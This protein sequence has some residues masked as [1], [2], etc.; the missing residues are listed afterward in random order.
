MRFILILF[1]LF[2]N[3]IFA[4]F[5]QGP[6]PSNGYREAGNPYYWK[7]RKPHEAYWQQDVHYRMRANISD[8]TDIIDAGSELTYW[9]NSPDT[10][11]IVYFHLYQNAFQP[12]SY[13][14]DLNKN[15][16]V[17]PKYGQYEQQGLGTQIESL[18]INGSAPR[19]E[20]DN[21]IMRVILPSPLYPGQS[22]DFKIKFK[23]YFDSGSL[24]RRMK[25]FDASG[26]KHF[27]GVHWYPRI[28][29]YDA[30][31]GWNTDQ[32]LGKEFYGDYG[33]YDVELTF[34]NHYVMDATGVLLNPEEVYP[35]DLRQKLD[36]SNFKNKPYNSPAS[37]I[38]KADGTTKTWKFHAENVHDFAWTADPTYRIGELS[39]NGVKCIA[40]AQ[41][42][43]ASGWQEAPSFIAKV[44]EVYSK[45]FGMY[46]YPKMIA[47]DAQ[48][49]MEYPMLTLDGGSYPGYHNVIAHEIGHNWFFG[50]VGNNETYRA[51]LDEG[52]T[53]FLTSWSLM[54]ID[55]KYPLRGQ[56]KSKYLERFYKP[57]PTLESSVYMG[58]MTDAINHNDEQLNTHSDQFNA[59]LGHGGGYRHVYYKTAVMLYNLE[60]VLG[61]ELFLK[62]MQ[63]YFHQWKMCHPYFEDF[64]ASI[65]RYTKVDLNWFFDQ[66]LETT[67]R[68]D[69]G[70]SGVKRVE[71]NDQFNKYKISFVRRDRMQMPV[72]FTVIGKSGK[73]YDFH[74]PNTYFVKAT[75]A[76]I[77]PMW[78]GWDK[79][80][81]T[82]SAIVT[83][84]EEIADV[85]ID[86]TNRLA[87]VN[88]LDNSFHMPVDFGFDAQIN[89]PA[90]RHNYIF[91][92]RPDVWYN[93]IDGIKAGLHFNGNYMQSKHNFR[94]SM[95]YNTG[96]LSGNDSLESSTKRD[97]FSYVFAYNTA[98]GRNFHS[99]IERRFL[100]GLTATRL[101]L[102]KVQGAN[103][104][105]LSFKSMYRGD[106]N[107]LNYLLYPDYWR[108]NAWNNTINIDFSRNYDYSFGNGNI[109]LGGRSSALTEDYDYTALNMNVINENRFG[110][111]DIRTRTFIQY[112]RGNS[113]APESKL[114][115]AGANPEGLMESKYTRSR[116][117]VPTDWV[118]YGVDY[119]HFHAGGGLNLRGYSNYVV[120]V[121][122]GAGLDSLN[123]GY[124]GAAVNAE[125]DFD[126]LVNFRPRFTRN[127]LKLDAYLFGDIGIL[128]NRYAKG[129]FNNSGFRSD[130]GVGTAWT[131]KR[132][133]VLNQINPLTI[134]F[135][136][137]VVVSHA[138]FV[139]NEHVRF[140]WV[141]GISRAF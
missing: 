126:R 36:L 5:Y 108:E 9:N 48:D 33:T 40:L 66:W 120:P 130:A 11:R 76:T 52:F 87:D 93:S 58:Y 65:I 62:A 119:N 49:G 19:I 56:Y 102:E 54:R 95:W 30:K 139:N 51:A 100:D 7:N 73:E 34:P 27:D 115:L 24:R 3:S 44:V 22:I 61:E 133:G 86:I 74:I 140:R 17:K 21:T 141:V 138:P 23:T 70:I 109:K 50:M 55:G 94:F 96:V 77:L 98:L 71:K 104:Y 124:S 1:V 37:E 32:H 12:G 83:I 89:N 114:Y 84:P 128:Y 28:C 68:I 80:N 15:N 18:T 110:K 106:R 132:F 16:D 45:D 136:V 131:I 91:R 116:G 26:Y 92:W 60:Y 118:G 112:G 113:F 14:H 134:R 42:S 8:Q 107:S 10:L 101:G 75:E 99:F 57:L 46:A 69:Y 78:K 117:I 2:S 85:K 31:F 125:I 67:K 13:F 123:N 111:I 63:N 88:E 137:P 122:D 64:R 121:P 79:I 105:T 129:S 4:Q 127:W 43:H 135:D 6:A 97:L 53:Q 103:T 39:W 29:V 82:Y 20:F 47:A 35:G 25:K 38:T 59:A 72:D 81:E 90:D 41:E